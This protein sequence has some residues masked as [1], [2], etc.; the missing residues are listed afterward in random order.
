MPHR[1]TMS[2]VFL[3]PITANRGGLTRDSP[4]YDCCPK[5]SLATHDPKQS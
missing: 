2:K 1:V 4:L 3:L 5:S